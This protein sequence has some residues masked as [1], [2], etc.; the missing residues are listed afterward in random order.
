MTEATYI[1]EGKLSACVEFIWYNDGYKPLSRKERVLPVGDAQLIINL[2]NDRFRHYEGTG[3][4]RQVEYDPVI[5]AGVHTGHIFLDSHTRISTIG[6]VLKPGATSALF[7]IPAG[8]F[9]NQVVSLGSFLK[10]DVTE[11]RQRL[12]AAPALPDKFSLV[13][14]F[15]SHHLD[16]ESQPNPAVLYAVEQ[17]NSTGGVQPISEILDNIGYSRRWFSEV[18]RGLNGLTPKQ[19]ARICR[20]QHTLEVIRSSQ[21]P[22]WSGLAFNCGYYDQPHFIHEFRNFAGISPTQYYRNQSSEMNHLPV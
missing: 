1:P 5:L 13:E 2:G 7:G 18:F 3:E 20:F 17:I 14:S 21:I 4:Q 22:D 16:P 9:K 10:T 19:Y 8:E 15:L 12:I 6:V 11:L